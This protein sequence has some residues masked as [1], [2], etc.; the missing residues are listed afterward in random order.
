MSAPSNISPVV[1]EVDES[2]FGQD[3]IQRSREVPV[4]VDFWAVWCGP[5]RTLGPILESLAREYA[6]RFVLAKLNVD[7]NQ[8]LAAQYNIQGIPAVKAFR[9]GK[10]AAEFVGALPR[11]A[12]RQFVEKLMPNGADVAVA[13]A[14]TLLQAGKAGEAAARLRA[15]LVDSPDHPAALL[16]LAEA[17][18]AGGRDSEALAILD[19]LPTA[20]AARLRRAIALRQAVGEAS[21]ADLCARLAANADDLSARYALGSLLSLQ[22]RYEEA[23]E[24]FLEN[25]RRDR[26]AER[27]R[28]REAML[29]LF[30]ILGDDPLA[31][32]YRN[33]LA[34]LLFA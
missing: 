6:G 16:G 29:H 31:R 24:Q 11:A 26:G 9:D 15:V 5:C 18:L 17:E 20:E 13:A 14:R 8:A 2:S 30:D 25:V 32:Q 7:E 33:R 22:D 4:I 23:L 19:R 12:V 10:V 27:N 1:I 21:E 34:S 28:A 3:V